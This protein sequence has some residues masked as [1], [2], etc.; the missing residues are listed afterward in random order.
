MSEW[1]GGWEGG[2]AQTAGLRRTPGCGRCLELLTPAAWLPPASQSSNKRGWR[3][4]RRRSQEPWPLH[5]HRCLSRARQRALHGGGALAAGVGG[6]PGESVPLGETLLSYPPRALSRPTGRSPPPTS[7]SRPSQVW[8]PR[9]TG[10]S[11]QVSSE[12]PHCIT[13]CVCVGGDDGGGGC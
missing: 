7:P 13:E 5:S 1:E 10:E 4:G 3:R 11:L 6:G 9:G 12:C 2:S 8:A